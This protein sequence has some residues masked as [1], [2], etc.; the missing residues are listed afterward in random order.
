MCGL[1]PYGKKMKSIVTLLLFA[2]MLSSVADEYV[3]EKTGI[4]LPAKI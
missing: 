4:K 3:H 1:E 2:T